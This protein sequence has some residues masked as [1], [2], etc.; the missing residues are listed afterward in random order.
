MQ[1]IHILAIIIRIFAIAIFIKSI[2][3]VSLLFILPYESSYLAYHLAAITGVIASLLLW[4][5]PTLVAKKIVPLQTSESSHKELDINDYY[6]LAFVLLGI[7]LLFN[8]FSD[9]VYWI[10]FTA[11]T[12]TLELP[13]VEF[14]KPENKAAMVTTFFE[15]ILALFLILRPRGIIKLFRSHKIK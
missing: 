8:V 2:E 13:Y 10:S 1:P 12:S 11:F 7:Y 9:I 5:F 3:G 15:F 14:I 6:H 4:F